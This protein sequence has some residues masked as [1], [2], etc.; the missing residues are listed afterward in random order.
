MI[1]GQDDTIYILYIHMPGGGGGSYSH[2][3]ISLNPA[4]GNTITELDIGVP[5]EYE[6]GGGELAIGEGGKLLYLNH[7]GYLAV[8]SSGLQ[9]PKTGLIQEIGP[10]RKLQ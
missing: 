4:D 2:K 3:W 1:M 6:G 5:E 9:I 10:T 7:K 8:F